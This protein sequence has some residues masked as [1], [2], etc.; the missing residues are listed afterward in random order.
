M[1]AAPGIQTFPD[2]REPDF[3]TGPPAPHQC[4]CGS[5]SRAGARYAED[6]RRILAQL[7][8]ADESMR[9]NHSAARGRLTVTAPVMFGTKFVTPIITEYL[10][11]YRE[12]SAS[13]W[14][15][16]RIANLVEEGADVAVRIDKSPGLSMRGV[17]VGR[18]RRV[19]CGAPNYLERQGIPQVPCDLQRHTI[20]C[21]S[22]VTPASEWRL[23]ED[24]KSCIVKLQPRLM[25][26]D[27]ESAVVAAMS[28]FGLAQ[29]LSYQVAD[30][31]R[32]GRLRIVLS[33]FEPIAVPVFVA[34]REGRQASPMARAFLDLAIARLRAD[35]ELN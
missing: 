5:A 22:G 32:D 29:L 4:L 19:I 11:L 25:T 3:E 7:A 34:H 2:I 28:G 23:K 24:G 14:F 17:Q 31:L 16:D 20:I 26:T 27:N 33:E 1:A 30:Q 35:P 6:C 12:A 10:N 8:E 9:G 21:A 18:V 15:A 13:C